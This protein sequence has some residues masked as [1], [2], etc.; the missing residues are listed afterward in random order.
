MGTTN[1][2][3]PHENTHQVQTGAELARAAAEQ[4]RELAEDLIERARRDGLQLVGE[5]GL[6]TG[7]VKLVLEGALEAEMAEHLGYEKGDPAGTG[8]GNQRN[9]TSRKTVL[10]QVGPVQIS[11][12][13]D[14]AGSF[15]PQI[16]P[17][18]ARRVEGFTETVVSLYAKGLTTGEI[19]AH[20]AEVYDVEVSRDL[21]SRATA[22]VAQD[23]AAWRTRPLDRV[24]AVLLIDCIYIKIRDG[25]VA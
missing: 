1:E 18:H 7:L 3:G 24:Y 23:L 19:Q 22:Q 6:L 11:I 12:P 9:G 4:N 25:A 16:V 13:R 15:T 10:S 17:K 21:V 5:N 8:S 20:L 14:R 2:T